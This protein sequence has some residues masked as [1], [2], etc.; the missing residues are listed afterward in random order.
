M[1]RHGLNIIYILWWLDG[2]ERKDCRKRRW[3]LSLGHADGCSDVPKGTKTEN[4]E[5]VV[6]RNQCVSIKKKE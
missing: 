6:G 2:F 5:V 3:R 4:D 1:N